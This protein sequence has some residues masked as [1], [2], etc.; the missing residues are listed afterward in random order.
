MP[1]D[2]APTTNRGQ[3]KSHPIFNADGTPAL[4]E[5]GSQLMMT[6]AEWRERNKS[7]GYTRIDDEAEEEVPVEGESDT[8][9]AVG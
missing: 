6:Q 5:D 2:K 3:E 4:N 1:N 7:A 8:E 9:T